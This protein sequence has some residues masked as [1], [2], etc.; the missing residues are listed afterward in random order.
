M[1]TEA[2]KE[3]LKDRTY[4]DQHIVAVGVLARSEKTLWYDSNF[5]RRFEA[6]K[7]YLNQVRPD[8]LDSFVDGFEPIRP[9]K[10]FSIRTVEALF[11]SATHQKIKDIAASIPEQDLEQH[12]L[13]AF[14]RY[15]VHDHPYFDELQRSIL[16][17]VSELAG[18]ELVPCYNF[19]SLYG[20]SG[21]C[22]VHMDEPQAMYTLDYCVDQSAPWPIHFS[23]IIDWPSRD[24]LAAWSA[25]KVLADP[26]LTFESYELEPNGAL[27]FNGSSQWH[28]REP[29]APGNFCNLLFFHYYPAGY[30]GLVLP[31][32][33]AE[34]FD[35][36]DL[37]P[38]CDLF[39]GNPY[40]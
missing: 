24:D 37:K 27:L 30:E 9:P 38:L 23:Q 28:Y 20:D 8:A 4:L 17:V 39:E 18:R 34:Y 32:K 12:E 10:D 21:K 19:L 1:L 2:V 35:L 29:N 16:P 15:V 11:D 6:A 7:E 13:K 36:P 26:S 25:E 22:G 5:L 3:R 33:W 40:I 14:G 31:E